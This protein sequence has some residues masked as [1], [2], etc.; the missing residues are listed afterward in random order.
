MVS[1]VI[2]PDSAADDISNY[3]E[4]GQAR[5]EEFIQQ[6]LKIGSPLSVWDRIPQLKLKRFST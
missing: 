1:G 3:P 4:K 5:Y 6:R 2:I